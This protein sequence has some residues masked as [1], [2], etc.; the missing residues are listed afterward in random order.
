MS[1]GTVPLKFCTSI[2]FLINIKTNFYL[3]QWDCCVRLAKGAETVVVGPSAG[4][5]ACVVNYGDIGINQST[6]YWYFIYAN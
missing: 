6:H 5:C 3:D 1:T 4:S 2:L